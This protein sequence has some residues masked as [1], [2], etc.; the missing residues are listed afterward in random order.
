[1]H[2]NKGNPLFAREPTR[3][4]RGTHSRG[5]SLTLVYYFQLEQILPYP[6][7]WPYCQDSPLANI[8]NVPVV[9]LTRFL[10]QYH[11]SLDSAIVV[12][13]NEKVTGNKIAKKGSE[14][15]NFGFF[16]VHKSMFWLFQLITLT[17][18][19]RKVFYLTF[20]GV[21]NVFFVMVL[22]GINTEQLILWSFHNVCLETLIK[23]LEVGEPRYLYV[24]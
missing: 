19:T 18:Q 10:L 11:T 7:Y 5:L 6:T 14:L 12:S 4:S 17:I 20:H 1:M 8:V 24:R 9:S 3:N 15:D 2:I 21:P 23:G 13:L 22:G 16:R